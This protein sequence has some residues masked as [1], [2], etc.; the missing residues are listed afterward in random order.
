MS[1]F[2]LFVFTLISPGHQR[3]ENRL[4]TALQENYTV[5]PGKFVFLEF[6]PREEALSLFRVIG[7]YH[8]RITPLSWASS[9]NN[10][11]IPTRITLSWRTWYLVIFRPEREKNYHDNPPL[12][13]DIIYRVLLHLPERISKYTP[14]S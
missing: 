2:L 12:H 3:E 7:N 10:V 11:K 13:S 8:F 5:I 6:F 9:L 14:E 4:T 1:V